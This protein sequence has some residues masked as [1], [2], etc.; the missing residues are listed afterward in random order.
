MK[1]NRTGG[2]E[3]VPFMSDF[4]A[5]ACRMIAGFWKDHNGYEQTGEESLN[6]LHEWTQ[7]EH[8]FLLIRQEDNSIGF[9]HLGSRGG[10]ID[11]LEDFYIIA[12]YRRRGIGT[13]V[14]QMVEAMVRTWSDS[15]Y[16]EAASRNRDAI[17]LYHSLGYDVLNT[18]TV[19]KD[20][21]PE[22]FETLRQE[23][24]DGM[25]FIVRRYS[26]EK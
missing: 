24:V 23:T 12:E 20:F 5:E 1:N 25:D 7:K 21:H 17:R 13:K 26:A 22:D 18:I 11:W 15:M 10:N 16:I 6:N 3:L 14:L 19:R 8:L 9:V 4:E 2:I